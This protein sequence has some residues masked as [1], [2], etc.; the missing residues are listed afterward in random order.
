MER[1]AGSA[2]GSSVHFLMV[3]VDP[4]PERTCSTFIKT[5]G[6]EK[7]IVGFCKDRSHFPSFP[8][9]LGCQGLVIFD[10]SGRIALGCSPALNRVGV[11]AFKKVDALAV[12][13]AEDAGMDEDDL[14]P[15]MSGRGRLYESAQELQEELYEATVAEQNRARAARTKRAAPAPSESVCKVAPADRYKA[16]EAKAQQPEKR[17]GAV[18]SVGHKEMDHEHEECAEAFERLRKERSTNALRDLIKLLADHFKHEEDLMEA[19]SFGAGSPAGLSPVISHKTDHVRIL[20]VA[21]KYL[22]A[23]LDAAMESQ[24]GVGP[25]VGEDC[26][27]SIAGLFETHATEFD[28]RYEGHLAA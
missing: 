16:Q 10:A 8:A 21:N 12:T 26:A 1:W 24:D 15:D 13:L 20:E 25:F 19:S 2:L 11:S 5:Y 9:Q 17:L 27:R 23:A 14:E 28:S 22:E 3:C 7:T 4:D 18:P 6:L